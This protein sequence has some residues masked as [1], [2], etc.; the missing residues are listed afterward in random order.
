MYKYPRLAAAKKRARE[1]GLPEPQSSQRAGKKLFVVY[2][3]K[4]IHFGAQ[5]YSDFLEHKDENRRQ[6]YRKRAQGA[7]LKSGK[8]AFRDRNQPAFYAYNI[9][10]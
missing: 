3:G 5:G 10:W 6:M 4:Q 7:T 8:P 2:N 1:L 9:L